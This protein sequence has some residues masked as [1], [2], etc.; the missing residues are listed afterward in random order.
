MTSMR[1]ERVTAV[2]AVTTAAVALPMGLLWA[3]P[4]AVQGDVQRLMYVHVP[5]A[6]VAYL[7]F[8][9][10]ALASAGYLVRR[11]PGWDRAA[12]A[13]AELGVGLTALSLVLGSIWAKPTW[14]TWWTWDPRLVTTVVLLLVYVGYLGVRGMASDPVLNARRAAVVGVVAI[15]NVPLVHFSV[16]WWRALHQPPTVLRP[17]GPAGELPPE[18]LLTLLV[19]LVAFTLGGGWVWLR[20]LRLLAAAAEATGASATGAPGDG[21]EATDGAPAELVVTP[22]GEGGL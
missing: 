21:T 5:A 16:V 22:R 13:A 17:G 20:R 14:G 19:S 10:V 1:I 6:W 3:P 15:V 11:R 8:G 4:D 9:V 18:M 2:A 7:C 12:Q